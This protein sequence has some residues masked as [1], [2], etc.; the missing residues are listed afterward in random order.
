MIKQLPSIF[1]IL[2]PK[3]K[4]KAS[5][6][7]FEFFNDQFSSRSMN[8]FR[9]S[10]VGDVIKNLNQLLFIYILFTNI[11]AHNFA[12]FWVNKPGIFGIYLYLI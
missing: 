8:E 1:T 10:I 12:L 6:E 5:F 9:L 11:P 4:N 7:T 2:L 3:T